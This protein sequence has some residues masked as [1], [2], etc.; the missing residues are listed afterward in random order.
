MEKIIR[1]FP[2]QIQN[3][4]RA[5]KLVRIP[6]F[7]VKNA[8]FVTPE[9]EEI[10]RQRMGRDLPGLCVVDLTYPAI[11]AVSGSRLEGLD[12]GLETYLTWSSKHREEDETARG[13][14]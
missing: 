4:V 14:L 6:N 11:V 9:M 7:P 8:R 3:D 1:N 5:E 12:G 13:S 10:Y 2:E